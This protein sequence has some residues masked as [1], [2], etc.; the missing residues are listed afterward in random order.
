MK[1]PEWS[2]AARPT[3]ETSARFAGPVRLG[4]VLFTIATAVAFVVR[5][6]V[7]FAVETGGVVGVDHGI[8]QQAAQRWVG[9][10]FFYYPE[11][12]SGPY[13]I[14]QGHILYPPVALAWLV[15]GAY[16]P[17]LLWWGIP[18]TVVVGR[19]SSTTAQLSG[20]G[21]SSA[22][23]W[24]RSPA[25][26]SSR[27]AIPGIW[28]VMFVALG[29]VWRPAFAL[30]LLKPSLF[31][32]ALPGIRSRGWWVIAAALAAISMLLLADVAATT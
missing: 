8:Y 13:E 2:R 11:Q 5:L 24:Q 20:R 28:I 22:F 12:V 4:L 7:V 10:G 26:R 6:R 23:A 25:L 30:V 9:G 19:S 17:D 31:L 14:V 27:L 32:F 3:P 29:T 21:R 16:L 15:P 1:S 18:I